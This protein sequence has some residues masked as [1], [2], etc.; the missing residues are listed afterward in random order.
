[1]DGKTGKSMNIKSSSSST[2][3]FYLTITYRKEATE[4]YRRMD[5]KRCD[6]VIFMVMG[7]LGTD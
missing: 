4:K 1:M 3:E 5:K 2:Q 6:A 7:K